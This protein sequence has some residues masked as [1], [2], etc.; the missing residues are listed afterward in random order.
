MTGVSPYSLHFSLVMR[1]SEH[2]GMYANCQCN[3][4]FSPLG[5]GLEEIPDGHDIEAPRQLYRKFDLRL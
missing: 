5:R 1:T 3:L 2:L 4:A